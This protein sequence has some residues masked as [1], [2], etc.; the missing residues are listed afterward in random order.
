ML[1]LKQIIYFPLIRI[2]LG[3]TICFGV[4]VGLEKLITKPLI[5]SLIDNKLIGD[6]IIYY[7]SVPVLLATYYYL[8]KYYEKRQIIELST[9]NL[10]KE[11]FG[12]FILGFS[13][14]SLV[15]LILYAFG[16]YQIIN[17]SSF[18]FFLAPFASIVIYALIEE[19]FFRAIL[20]RILENKLGTYIALACI[21]ILFEIPH[22]FNPNITFL[23]V[24]LGLLFGFAHGIMYTYTNRIW[25]PFGFHVGW[26]LAQPFYGSNLSGLNDYNPVFESKFSGPELITGSIYGIEDSILSNLFLLIVCVV[27][28]YLAIKKNKIVP[29]KNKLE[30][31]KQMF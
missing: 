4:L 21:S 11:L 10:V 26:N 31:S 15:V 2:V 5:Y 9:S 28:L 7:V 12:G 1:E 13:I 22:L 30:H 20:Y 27:F 14:L 19:V 3:I 25:L 29:F 24:I 8:F 23:S 17:F 6:T 16:Y 18:S